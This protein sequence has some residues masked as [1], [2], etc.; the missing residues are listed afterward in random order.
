MRT[1]DEVILRMAE[2]YDSIEICDLLGIPVDILLERFDDYVEERM[3]QLQE[4]LFDEPE[5]DI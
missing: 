4:E 1:L 3:D 2:V 5:Q